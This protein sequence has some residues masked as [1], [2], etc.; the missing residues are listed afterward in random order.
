MTRS[1][2]FKFAAVAAAAVISL[3]AVCGG[4]F[5]YSASYEDEISSLEE[6]RAEISEKRE[7]LEAQLNEYREGA[8]AQEGYLKLYNEKME[9]QE[10]EMDNLT[11]QIKSTRSKETASIQKEAKDIILFVQ[12]FLKPC[13]A[14]YVTLLNLIFI[15]KL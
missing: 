8:E 13:P 9:L 12:I 7:A 14:R 2:I 5:G 10:E 11:T 4:D 6:R 15:S 3:S 1:F